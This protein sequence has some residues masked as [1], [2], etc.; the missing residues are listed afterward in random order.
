VAEPALIGL[1]AGREALRRFLA[2]I[3]P[4][5]VMHQEV[6]E[7]AADAVPGVDEASLT[8]ISEGQPMTSIYIGD[9]ALEL[10]KVQYDEGDGPCLAALRH[11][12]LELVDLADDERWPR[13][14]DVGRTLGIAATL[15]APLIDGEGAKGALNL[16]STTEFGPEAPE[17]A[18]LFADQLGVAAVNAALY[19]RSAE[20][21]GQLRAAMESRA[22]I[23]QA[24]GIIM[25]V[26]RCGPDEAFDTLRQQSQHENHKLR[27]ISRELVSRVAN[28]SARRATPNPPDETG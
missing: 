18:S 14:C 11:Q 12:G 19:V 7:L 4:L 22:V 27:E 16:Y 26:L 2:G 21:A 17:V 5:E 20:V 13:F 10:D 3:D 23:E 8:I 24:K 28:P 1:D 25:Q 15:S 6:L 9:R